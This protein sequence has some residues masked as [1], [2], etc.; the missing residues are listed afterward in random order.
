MGNRQSLVLAKYDALLHYCA[1]HYALAV[2]ILAE[3]IVDPR[4][5]LRLRQRLFTNP[6]LQS[7]E[8]RWQP[9]TQAALP[10]IS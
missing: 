2:G 3:Q 5:V 8:D 1:H 9:L 7:R 10:R 6:A 4:Q